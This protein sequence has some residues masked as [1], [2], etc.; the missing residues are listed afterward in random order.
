MECHA[1]F[2]LCFVDNKPFEVRYDE[3]WL[4]TTPL[5]TLD[6]T[7][8]SAIGMLFTC[9]WSP[10]FGWGVAS[11][12]FQHDVNVKELSEAI[13]IDVIA[14]KIGTRESLITRIGILSISGAFFGRYGQYYVYNVFTF[15]C[16]ES[17]LF[18]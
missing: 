7:G 13:I 2:P 5:K 16:L 18:R 1:L 15:H 4:C 12:V 17:K 8:R 9:S 14:G 10:S 11:A 6:K 3:N